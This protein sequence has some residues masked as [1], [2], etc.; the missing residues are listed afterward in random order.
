MEETA[1]ARTAVRDGIS[2]ISPRALRTRLDGILETASMTPGALTVLTA[3][4]LRESIE[5]DTAARRGAGIQMSY[6]GLR[7]SRDLIHS[8]PWAAGNSSDGDMN[9]IAAEILVARGFEY[10]AHTVVAGDVVEAVRRFGYDQ[11]RREDRDADHV[12]L[13]RR[14]EADFIRIA[15]KAGADIALGSIPEGVDSLADELAEELG[16]APLPEADTALVGIEE[17]I[18][19][20]VAGPDR[21]PTGDF[22]QSSGT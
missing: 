12:A 21:T 7:L 3:T 15:V 8:D 4:A 18:R 1:R 11:T 17:R 22:S 2:D 13:D 19:K 6:E 16:S 20:A 5:G 10:L 9:A 14:L